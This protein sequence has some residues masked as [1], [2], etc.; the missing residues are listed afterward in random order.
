MDKNYAP[1]APTVMYI[2][3]ATAIPAFATIQPAQ[4][5]NQWQQ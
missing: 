2:P 3:V 4:V 1:S 5:P